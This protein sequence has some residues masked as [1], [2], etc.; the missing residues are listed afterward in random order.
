M[1]SMLQPCGC[2]GHVMSLVCQ[3][4]HSL[5]LFVWR[6]PV[7]WF[8]DALLSVKH[9]LDRRPYSF[10]VMISHLRFSCMQYMMTYQLLLSL[11]RNVTFFGGSSDLSSTQVREVSWAVHGALPKTL[12]TTWASW[13]LSNIIYIDNVVAKRCFHY[14]FSHISMLAQLF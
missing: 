14:A 11:A 6:L 9:P 12:W 10:L 3:M 13:G 8:T 4:T 5:S 2:L 1:A 7:L